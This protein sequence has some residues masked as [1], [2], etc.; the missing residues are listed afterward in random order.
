MFLFTACSDETN[1]NANELAHN[2]ENT[3][4]NTAFSNDP[5]ILYASPFDVVGATGANYHVPVI[6]DM[7]IPA[8]HIEITPYLGPMYGEYHEDWVNNGMFP[9]FIAYGAD[10]TALP[11]DT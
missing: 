8:G 7:N 11:T 4:E 10:V 6:F 9:N 3:G 5:G 1:Y 2:E